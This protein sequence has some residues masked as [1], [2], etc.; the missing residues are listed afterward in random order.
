[1]AKTYNAKP[2]KNLA[3]VTT[4][5][6]GE[7]IIFGLQFGMP[8]G[9]VASDE[10]FAIPYDALS[11]VIAGLLDAGGRANALREKNPIH[12]EG[13][14]TGG[15][16]Y[17]LDNGAISPSLLHKGEHVLE[18]QVRTP[19]GGELKYLIRA[20]RDGLETLHKLLGWYLDTPA[21]RGEASH[22]AH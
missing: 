14:E 15:F 22:P 3:E 20:D 1:M 16:A 2:V 6:N 12:S 10:Y 18:C 21:G 13:A 5:N 4:A 19:A 8:D 7:M 9:D 11:N 17:K